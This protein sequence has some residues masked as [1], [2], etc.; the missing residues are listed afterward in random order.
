MGDIVMLH[1]LPPRDGY[2]TLPLKRGDI[3]EVIDRHDDLIMV[4]FYCGTIWL[5][6]DS[7]EAMSIV[8]GAEAAHTY[9]VYPRDMPDDQ[10]EIVMPRTTQLPIRLALRRENHMWC[11]YLKSVGDDRQPLLLGSIR[12]VAI[13]NNETRKQQFMQLMTE[14]MSEMIE[15]VT[16]KAPDRFEVQEA[17]ESERGGNG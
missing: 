2:Y 11:A 14:F 15:T 12:I 8:P 6:G 9:Y 5:R 7:V 4:K 3:G 1:E 16:G 10:T 17:P 13:E